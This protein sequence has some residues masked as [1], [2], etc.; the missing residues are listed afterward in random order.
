[1]SKPK[2]KDLLAGIL[3]E[4]TE[5]LHE[6]T[7]TTKAMETG[8]ARLTG[9]T[10]SRSVN[11]T[12]TKY[13]DYFRWVSDGTYQLADAGVR[14]LPKVRNAI[15]SIKCARDQ[16]R[17]KEVRTRM[18]EE[19]PRGERQELEYLR[20]RCQELEQKLKQISAIASTRRS[21]K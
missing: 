11:N 1:M 21:R 4:S 5:P 2:L 8:I 13:S 10:P 17:I 16:T 18:E 9:S 6:S 7:L 3:S 19:R 15:A 12:L 14:E 20:R